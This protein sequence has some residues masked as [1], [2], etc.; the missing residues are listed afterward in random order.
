MANPPGPPKRAPAPAPG[1]DTSTE[2][3]SLASKLTDR[4]VALEQYLASQPATVRAEVVFQGE[5]R[6][7]RLSWT[8]HSGSWQ[9]WVWDVPTEEEEEHYLDD[10]GNCATGF[11]GRRLTQCSVDVKLAAA[12]AIPSLLEK[13]KK[14][15]LKIIE[16]LKIVH[17]KLDE[18]AG[19]SRE[20]V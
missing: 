8:R 12:E 13:I 11:N 5:E 16:R 18:L 3:V 1:S 6:F 9:L 15:E 2:F 17:A 4:L 19:N 14:G 20:G 10:E 7:H